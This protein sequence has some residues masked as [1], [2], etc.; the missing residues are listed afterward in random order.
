MKFISSSKAFY[1]FKFILFML[2]VA[3][4]AQAAVILKKRISTVIAAAGAVFF[5]GAA[6]GASKIASVACTP[7]AKAALSQV[8]WT[9]NAAGCLGWAAGAMLLAAA[10][11]AFATAG[12]ANWNWVWENAGASSGLSSRGLAVLATLILLAVTL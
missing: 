2:A 12:G 8:S 10:G 6:Y 11:A 1:G 7:E 4:S 9:D 5:F 3:A